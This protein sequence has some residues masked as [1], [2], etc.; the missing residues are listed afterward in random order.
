VS[1]NLE[2]ILTDLRPAAMRLAVHRRRRRR[3]K[4]TTAT[5]VLLAGL[6]TSAALG[7]GALFSPAPDSIKR[8]LLAIDAGMPADL[9]L[10]PDVEHA[11]AVAAAGDSIVYFAALAEGGYC[12][13]LAVG[14]RGR[15]AVCSTARQTDTT[16]LSV[17]IPFD[18]PVTDHSPVVVSGHV[19]LRDAKSVE[20]VYPDGAREEV[21]V[22]AE[23]FY[24]A[25]V[26]DAHLKAVHRGGLMLVARDRDGKPLAEA[27]VPMDAITPPTEAERPNDPLE[28]ETVTDEGDLSRLLAIDGRTRVS[29]A[30]RARLTYPDGSRAETPIS[31]GSF[32]FDIPPRKRGA[33]ARIPGEVDVLD[34]AGKVV[35]S[36]PVAAVSYWHAH[37]R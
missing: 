24:V 21:A 11:H 5:I 13:E 33:M 2:Q 34:A 20:L 7:A 30:V 14:G 10:N 6:A 31:G 15:G 9:R 32:R 23:R 27:V 18:D 26:P 29:G 37:E 1:D 35:A 19:S 12:A 17:T 3:A 28:V 25:N 22:S 16:P 36:R 8:S 4:R